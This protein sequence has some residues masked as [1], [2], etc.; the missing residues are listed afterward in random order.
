V[1][2]P[3]DGYGVGYGR[4]PQ[5]TRWKKG[6]S[7]NSRRRE[8]ARKKRTLE[9]IDELLTQPLPITFMGEQ[10]TVSKLEAIIMQLMQKQLSGSARA[11]RILLK[12]EEFASANMKKRLAVRF[13]ENDYTRAFANL[14][15]ED[16][17]V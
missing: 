11:A 4:P 15:Q 7:G 9:V 12:Y 1:K 6:Q 2:T 14:P 17:N 16:E 5:E 10:K 13:V 3:P 8:P